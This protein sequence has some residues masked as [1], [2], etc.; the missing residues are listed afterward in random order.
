MRCLPESPHVGADARFD[1]PAMAHNAQAPRSIEARPAKLWRHLLLQTLDDIRSALRPDC[2][3]VESSV[4]LMSDRDAGNWALSDSIR[5]SHTVRAIL[6]HARQSGLSRLRILNASG[7][8]HGDLDVSITSY[9]RKMGINYEWLSYESPESPFLK[10]PALIQYI[11]ELNIKIQHVDYRNE[12]NRPHSTK[13]DIIIFTE[14]AEHLD[15][16]AFI[17][18]IHSLREELDDNGIL[19]LA[20]PNLLAIPNRVRVAIGYGDG[21]YFGDGFEN[22]KAGLYGHVTNYDTHRLQRLLADARFEVVYAYTFNWGR[23]WISHN[24]LKAAV[25]RAMDG[26]TSLISNSG[27]N[28]FLVARATAL[29][30]PIPFAT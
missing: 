25:A 15:H 11:D 17:K 5:H 28:V 14:I 22:L 23:A 6:R 8:Y 2:F 27:Q 19:I 1:G 7:L 3:K 20:T 16:S 21:P 12:V 9:L 30:R 13:Q 10:N 24:P 18:A 26:L 29:R 4:A